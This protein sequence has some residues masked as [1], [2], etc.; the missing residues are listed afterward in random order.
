MRAER[1]EPNYI[2]IPET[3]TRIYG[4]PRCTAYKP[5]SALINSFFLPYY[6]SLVGFR[7]FASFP[8]FSKP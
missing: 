2:R 7:V 8:V 4:S 6:F 5:H 1:P 3:S